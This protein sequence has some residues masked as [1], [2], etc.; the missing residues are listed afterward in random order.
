LYGSYCQGFEND[1]IYSEIFHAL[2]HIQDN[3][4]MMKPAKWHKCMWILTCLSISIIQLLFIKYLFTWS[5]CCVRV[6]EC[7][8]EP[9]IT[10]TS[11]VL[12]RIAEN[13]GVEKLW[14]EFDNFLWIHQSVIHQLLVMP[15]KLGAGLKFAEVFFAKCNLAC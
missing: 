10:W 4:K 2:D 13:F 1:Y 8:V 11:T 12:Y 3:W 9:L 14:G 15:E 5:A 6:I 7:T